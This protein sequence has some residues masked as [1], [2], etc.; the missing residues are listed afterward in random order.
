MATRT[1]AV[2][3][4]PRTTT[5]R[6]L[7]PAEQSRLEVSVDRVAQLVAPLDAAHVAALWDR[8]LEA[9]R[10][11]DL[12]GPRTV[13]V[14]IGTLLLDADESARWV[15]CLGPRGWTPGVVSQ[16]R[17]FSPVLPV[18]DALSRWPGASSSWIGPY[19]DGSLD[20]LVNPDDLGDHPWIA[21]PDDL[22]EPPAPTVTELAYTALNLGQSLAGDEPRAFAVLPGSGGPMSAPAPGDPTDR[23][24][25]R[26]WA[27]SWGLQAGT[28]IL[29]VAW[30]E[31]PRGSV[32]HAAARAGSIM[33]EASEAGRPGLTIVH[34]FTTG[35]GGTSP[36]GSPVIL[37]PANPVL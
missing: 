15:S 25:V 29:A 23:D 8:L 3:T 34:E 32:R 20:H 2:G 30:V 21:S 18:A 27:R 1:N 19:V 6:D 17:P 26:T 35:P 22:P 4:D 28:P 24:A 37:G 16:A 9:G 36:S 13:G 5:P 33:V 31:P 12:E 10:Y 7:T 14:A 11:D